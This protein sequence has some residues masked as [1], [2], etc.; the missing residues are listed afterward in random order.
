MAISDT[1]TIVDA[2]DSLE[3]LRSEADNV[4]AAYAACLK[5]T[6]DDQR[7]AAWNH[8]VQ[9]NDSLI[10]KILEGVRRSPTSPEAFGLLEWVMTN[11]RISAKSLR[12]YGLQA[13]E[14]LREHYTSSTNISSI[15]WQLG[16][17][18]DPLNR[19]TVEFLQSASTNN[20]DRAARGR[21]T[22]ALALLTKRTGEDMA[23][24]QAV[25]ASIYTN[26]PKAMAA[27]ADDAKTSDPQV[28]LHQAEQLFQKVKT[29][30]SDVPNFQAGPGLRK[31]EPTLGDQ[32]SIEL[33][34]CQHLTAGKVAPEIEGEDI[35]GH[36]LRLSDYRGKVVV[37]S[38]WASWCGPCMQMVPHERAIA[39]RL[40]GKPFVLVGV[41]GDSEKPAAKRAIAENKMTWQSFWNGGSEG[42]IAGTWNVHA[43]PTVYVLDSKGM[44]RLKFEGYGGKR[45]DALLD[46]MVD[47]LLE[48][49]ERGK[50]QSVSQNKFPDRE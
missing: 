13:I 22:F 24:W 16:F 44:I 3:T 23:W 41:N 38:F 36:K 14:I 35:E 49:M 31:P 20:P 25:P 42:G 30:Y 29:D 48:E 9:V 34:E 6:A 5:A 28:V 40:A 27:L 17:S 19:P 32:A 33:Y 45:G 8:Y 2:S 46:A 50:M 11:G 26:A 10:P 47:R 1:K 4:D 18:G 15:C 43:W 21:A 12:P 39:E 7:E 37:V